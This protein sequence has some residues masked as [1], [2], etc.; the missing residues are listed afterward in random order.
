MKESQMRNLEAK[1][2]A[3]S[4]S[5][6]YERGLAA[7]INEIGGVNFVVIYFDAVE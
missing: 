1:T 5:M 6:K 2:M 7:A 4:F 3:E